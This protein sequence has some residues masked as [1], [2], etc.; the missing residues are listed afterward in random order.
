V[1]WVS[2]V[3][4]RV[5]DWTADAAVPLNIEAT[6]MDAED[7]NFETGI[8]T[9]LTKDGQNTPTSN[10]PMATQR[11][12]GVGD[13]AAKTD[14]ASAAD[15]I[16]QHL[17]FYVDSGAA[18]AY[19]IT[20]SPSIG[21][22]AEGQKLVFRAT[23][24]N[25]GASTLNV[26]GLGALAIQTN[27]GV[28]LSGGEILVGGYYEVVHDVN[29]T[30]DRF[31]L[32]SPVNFSR[33]VLK[34]KT[35]LEGAVGTA[36][37]DDDDLAGYAIVAN[38]EYK[39]TARMNFIHTGGDLKFKLDFTNAPSGGDVVWFECWDES[40]VV[41]RDMIDGTDTEVNITT[42]SSSQDFILKI[43]ALFRCSSASVLDFQFAK[44]AAVG[45]NTSNLTGSWME[46]TQM[47]T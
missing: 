37:Q 4:S 28:A 15:V 11:H 41:A 38:K 14:Y 9:C 3:F 20:P 17:S 26:N 31:V 18:D 19:V 8:N 30:P 2:G 39:L 25:T 5:H 10:L 45:S 34:F 35:A 7:D 36:L 47:E 46:V 43:G 24:A 33:T 22:Y 13:A 29:S 16:D 1:S 32:M 42:M 40:A 44:N 23:N 27:D 6:R 12:T 21:A